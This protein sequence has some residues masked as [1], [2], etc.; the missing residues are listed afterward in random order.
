MEIL[1]RVDAINDTLQEHHHEELSGIK[2]IKAACAVC[3]A[4]LVQSSGK[5]WTPENLRLALILGLVI[6][7][8]TLGADGVRALIVA[9][10]H[11]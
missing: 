1:R 3:P 7:V 11:R 10:T 9:L 5:L 6:M 2:D 4:R 8:S